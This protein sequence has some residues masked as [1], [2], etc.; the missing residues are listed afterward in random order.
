MKVLTFGGEK[1]PNEVVESLLSINKRGVSIYNCYGQSE[2]ANDTLEYEIIEKGEYF[3]I[4][5]GKPIIN[6]RAYIMGEDMDILP[7]GMP[8]ELCISG[9][10][11]ASGYLNNNKRTQETFFFYP[12]EE[13]RVY[14][15]GDRAKMHPDGNI[16]ILG[17]VDEQIK[18][19]GY[20]VE[21]AEI[22]FNLKKDDRVKDV[23]IINSNINDDQEKI[24]VAYYT[25]FLKKSIDSRELKK[26]LSDF[27]PDYMIPNRFVF[28]ESFPFNFNG[29]IDKE[30]LPFPCEDENNDEID[31]D[32]EYE[33][34]R[35]F[36]EKKII[37]IWKDILRT[38]NIKRD[39]NFFDLGGHS[40][41]AINM[42]SR[43]NKVF[44]IDFRLKDVF[45]NPTLYE[46]AVFVYNKI[47]EEKFLKD[48]DEE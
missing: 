17:R 41:N 8:G 18:I 45:Q 5:A 23:V 10:G 21:P 6:T 19:R 47:W 4:P 34:P 36:I 3:F 44:K 30:S 24:L 27:L 7:I 32:A 20:R 25:T 28:L 42:I 1:T 29:K 39:S 12:P 2:F 31:N 14:K 26:F 33:K 15:T 46:Q 37:E 9:D 43:I 16:E 48:I 13:E 40:L 38:E 35:N 22:E 11:M